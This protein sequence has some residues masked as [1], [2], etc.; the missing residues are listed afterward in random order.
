MGRRLLPKFAR[1]FAI[2]LCLTAVCGGAAFV[3]YADTSFAVTDEPVASKAGEGTYISGEHMVWYE[4]DGK[5]RQ[6]IFYRNLSTG[7]EKQ[8]TNYPSM[9]D[10]PRVTVTSSGEVVVV[11]IDKKYLGSGSGMWDVLAYYMNSQEEVK[12]SSVIAPHV[13]LSVSGDHV[14]WYQT[15]KGEMYAYD[16]SAR[17][18]TPLGLGTKPTVVNGNIAFITG[19]GDIALHHLITGETKSLVDLP[20]HLYP[21]ELTYNGKQVLWKESDLD[22]RTKYVLLDPSDAGAAPV[23]LTTKSK[24]EVEYPNLY[25][26]DGH[27]AWVEWNAGTPRLTGVDLTAKQTYEVAR[28]D[29]VIHTVSFAGDRLIMKAAD[30]RLVA[31]S[32]EMSAPAPAERTEGESR[33]RDSLSATTERKAE[34]SPVRAGP[35]GAVLTSKDGTARLVIPAGALESEVEARFEMDAVIQAPNEAKTELG[36]KRGATLAWRVDLDGRTLPK[37]KP[38]ELALKFDGLRWSE[39]ERE[40]MSIYRWEAEAKEWKR[41]GGTADAETFEI[42]ASL[43]RSG[44]YAAF[45]YDVAF[46]DTVGHWAERPVEI[47]AALEIV[48]GMEATRFAPDATLT[49]A[50]FTKMLLGAMGIEPETDGG[51]SFTD[52]AASH[53]AA[54]WVNAAARAGIV[55]GSNGTFDPESAL[56][57]EQMVA[58][59][60]RALERQRPISE[61]ESH[62]P[63]DDASAISDWARTS[64]ATAAA[65]GLIQG[66][67]GKFLPHASSTRAEAATVMYRLLRVAG[68]L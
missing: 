44:T 27:A 24:K 55:Q 29:H 56:T 5:G 7:V 49:R 1:R 61:R 40:K 50:Q 65:L 35:M 32:L 2:G 25:L 3:A 22:N 12:L 66:R 54:P 21:A 16:L 38:A 26:G 10:L 8:V 14:A 17:K 42:R 67:D 36:V 30:G 45:V 20:Y 46:S 4:E 28:G 6:N 48:N 52:V 51:Q 68:D 64:A 59:L 34:A 63:F 18:E 31:R 23:D 39:E 47:L 57:R 13:G 19:D 9:K 41:I 33:D 11:W 60:V 43:T 37:D 62:L 58:M 15:W 53:W